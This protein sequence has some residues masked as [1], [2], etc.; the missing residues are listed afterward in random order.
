MDKYYGKF[1]E[2]D[3]Y[4]KLKRIF[5]NNFLKQIRSEASYQLGK[6]SEHESNLYDAI[7]WYEISAKNENYKSFYKLS[8]LQSQKFS[9]AET[10]LQNSYY[11]YLKSSAALGYARAMIEMAFDS[12][13]NSLESFEMAEKILTQNNIFELTK[14]ITNEAKMIYFGNEIKEVLEICY[15]ENNFR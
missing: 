7:K 12:H 2:F 3:K 15:E 4:E 5:K 13:L 8:K 9:E 10:N 1:T 14:A 6:Y 11:K